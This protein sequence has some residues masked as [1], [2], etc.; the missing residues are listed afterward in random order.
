MVRASD[1]SGILCIRPT[2]LHLS[3]VT[4]LIKCLLSKDD[5]PLMKQTYAHHIIAS[6]GL[7]AGMASGYHINQTSVFKS[8]IKHIV[9]R[10][11]LRDFNSHDEHEEPAQRP[12]ARGDAN[13][14]GK[15]CPIWHFLHSIANRVVPNHPIPSGVRFEPASPR[16]SL[17]EASLV[18]LCDY[19]I[20]GDVRHIDYLGVDHGQD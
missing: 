7:L 2:S 3:N 10:A 16:F 20:R 1:I 5:S 9:L 4:L 11:D 6:L 12:Q 15:R 8:I 18:L 19:P 13:L 17:V 14:R